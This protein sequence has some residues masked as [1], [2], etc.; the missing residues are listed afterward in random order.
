ML[1]MSREQLAKAKVPETRRLLTLRTGGLVVFRHW[2]LLPALQQAALQLQLRR[3][4]DVFNALLDFIESLGLV[5][6]T[7]AQRFRIAGSQLLD[8]RLSLLLRHRSPPE[9]F[10]ASGA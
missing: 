2:R 7:L 4:S 10:H 3:A 6:Q 9:S 8:Q 1:A 5:R